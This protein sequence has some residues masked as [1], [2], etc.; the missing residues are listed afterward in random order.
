LLPMLI[1]KKRA[2][3]NE[4]FFIIIKK[5]EAKISTLLSIVGLV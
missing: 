5:G 3:K 2:M 4:V 1:D